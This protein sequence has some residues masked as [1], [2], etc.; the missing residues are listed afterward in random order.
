MVPALEVA[1][2]H[3]SAPDRRIAGIERHRRA[4]GITV[5]VDATFE[6]KPSV[7]Y[8]ATAVPGG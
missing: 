4:D 7:L 6:N 5:E 8:D 1:V 3:G 2:L